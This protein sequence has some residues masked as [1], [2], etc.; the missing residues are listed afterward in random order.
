MALFLLPAVRGSRNERGRVA[1]HSLIAR[2]GRCVGPASRPPEPGCCCLWGLGCGRGGPEE[3]GQLA[4]DRDD[5]DVVML[6]ARLHRG[7]GVV[8]ALLGA[9]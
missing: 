5:R 9:V 3:A 1:A 6:A 4:R 2:A 7:V 8:Q